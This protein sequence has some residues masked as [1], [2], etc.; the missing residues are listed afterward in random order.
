MT[1]HPGRGPIPGVIRRQ[2]K[3]KGRL[4]SLATNT[5]PVRGDGGSVGGPGTSMSVGKRAEPGEVG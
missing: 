1:H 4:D 2:R 3:I 5:C